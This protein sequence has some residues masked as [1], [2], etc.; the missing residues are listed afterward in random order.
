MTMLF[1]IIRGLLFNL[2][3][4][5][6][7]TVVLSLC[8]QGTRERA[9][10]QPVAYSRIGQFHRLTAGCG[11]SSNKHDGVSISFHVEHF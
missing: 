3:E 11:V 8:M 10:T 1:D 5:K 4:M 7:C 6:K 9:W 2:D